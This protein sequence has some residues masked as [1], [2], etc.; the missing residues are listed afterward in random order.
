MRTCSGFEA[1][2]PRNRRYLHY[3][4]RGWHGDYLPA[5][6]EYLVEGFSWSASSWHASGR[7]LASPVLNDEG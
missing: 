4:F 6:T 1:D 3:Q 5:M 2:R 7:V